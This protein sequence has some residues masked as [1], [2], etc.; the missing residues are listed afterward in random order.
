VKLGWRRIAAIGCGVFVV[1]S[2]ACNAVDAAGAV[3]YEGSTAPFVSQYK[4]DLDSF[5]AL[6]NKKTVHL[7]GASVLSITLPDAKTGAPWL[8]SLKDE[9][10]GDSPANVSCFISSTV[11]SAERARALAVRKGA[12]IDITARVA[13][14]GF[15]LGLTDCRVVQSGLVFGTSGNAKAITA[16]RSQAPRDEEPPGHPITFTVT[17]AWNDTVNGTLFVHDAIA[18]TGGA[19][20]VTVQPGDFALTM[21]LANGAKKSYGSMTE[22]APTYQKLS[23]LSPNNLTTAYEVDPKDDLGSIGPITVP[24][25]GSVHVIITF[26]VPDT[27]AAPTDNRA[28]SLR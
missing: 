3:A 1:F 9:T 15:S 24:A 27:V 23:A 20:D 7:T 13:A 19:D 5:G 17:N 10:G 18:I 6:F 16:S 2:C 21:Q 11:T 4:S 25:H 14:D 26:Q 28:V 8:I 22:A 12:R